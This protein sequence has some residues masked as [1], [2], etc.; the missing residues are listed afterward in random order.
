[1]ITEIIDLKCFYMKK[2]THSFFGNGLANT[3]LISSLGLQGMSSKFG[4]VSPN[5]NSER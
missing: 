1:V 2:K 3:S 4:M 5:M